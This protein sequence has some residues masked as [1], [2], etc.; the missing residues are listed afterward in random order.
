MHK[1][2]YHTYHMLKC[3]ESLSTYALPEAGPH[4]LE[5]AKV[6]PTREPPPNPSDADHESPC[7]TA[8]DLV[9]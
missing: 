7:R 1:G 4:K 6:D 9:N 5:R 3:E 8:T 2:S